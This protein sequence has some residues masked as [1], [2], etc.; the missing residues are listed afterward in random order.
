MMKSIQTKKE[1][2]T[3]VGPSGQLK[4]ALA[5]HQ[6]APVPDPTQLAGWAP[7]H[8][9]NCQPRSKSPFPELPSFCHRSVVVV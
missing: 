1:G 2:P 7:S 8:A 4:A 3:S 9:T 6:L 5:I